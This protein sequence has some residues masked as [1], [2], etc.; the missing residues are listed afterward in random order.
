MTILTKSRKHKAEPPNAYW[1]G[2]HF[3][4][5]LCM[6]FISSNSKCKYLDELQMAFGFGSLLVKGGS[7]LSAQAGFKEWH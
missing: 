1:F 3:Q 4:N 5:H 2:S 6:V 7:T